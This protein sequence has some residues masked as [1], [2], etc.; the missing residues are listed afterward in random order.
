MGTRTDDFLA[1]SAVPQPKKIQ[2]HFNIIL[3]SIPRTSDL[4]SSHHAH[5]GDSNIRL[6]ANCYAQCAMLSITPMLP[7]S[8]VQTSYLTS[9]DGQSFSP[10]PPQKGIVT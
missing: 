6:T 5:Y 8:Q 1:C 3:P 2:V 4:Y 7:L 10:P 9:G